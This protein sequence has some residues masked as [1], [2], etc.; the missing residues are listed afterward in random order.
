VPPTPGGSYSPA[1]LEAARLE[2]DDALARPRRHA[3]LRAEHDR[4]G[5]ARLDARRL[6]PDVDPIRAQGA[7][8]RFVIDRADARDVERTS[9]DAVAAA[10]AAVADEVD[11][12]VGVLHDRARR[13][14]GLQAARILAV[15]SPTWHHHHHHHHHHAS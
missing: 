13:R 3:G 9:F 6:Q 15:P 1:F 7:F 12:A 2:V 4:F 14:A 10:D 8:V 11:D 5:R